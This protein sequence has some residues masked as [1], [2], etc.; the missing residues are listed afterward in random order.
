MAHH[1]NP[2]TQ[3]Y[4]EFTSEHDSDTRFGAAGTA[5]K[6]TLTGAGLL[7]AWINDS[8]TTEDIN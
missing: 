8:A 4:S 6:H 3:T 2:Q 7:T 5:W 1:T